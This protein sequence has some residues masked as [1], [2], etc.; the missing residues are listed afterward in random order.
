VSSL[1]Y[2]VI[3]AGVMLGCRSLEDGGPL[4]IGH[5]FAGFKKNAGSLL[6]V[7]VLY[8]VGMMLIGFIAGI[9][10][11]ITIPMML[12]GTNFDP[13]D[14]NSILAVAPVFLL[15][16]LVVLAL[17]LPL[18]MALWFAPAI[19]VFH[20]M[21]PMAAMRASFQG[22]LRN[23]MPFLLYGIVG[24]LLGILALVPVGLGLLIYGPVMW[25]TMYAGYRDI[26]VR[27]A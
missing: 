10:A 1:C 15:I 18:I 26:F 13:N 14:F 7:G 20:D 19:V 22:C 24:L 5:L 25:G 2:P 27:P 23:F 4:E 21:A 8:L 3:V 16:V 6:L 11:A 12:G 17:M 9:A